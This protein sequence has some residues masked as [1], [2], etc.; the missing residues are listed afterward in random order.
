[1]RVRGSHSASGREEREG[2]NKDGGKRE[3][4]G[5]WEL[6][7]TINHLLP[8]LEFIW[9]LFFFVLF[10]FESTRGE[11]EKLGGGGQHG[12]G[13]MM[14]LPGSEGIKR[15]AVRLICRSFK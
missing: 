1:M 14:K 10:C 7:T 12:G 6:C 2:G 3:R 8:G 13:G 11:G 5:E 4:D 15:E 9:I